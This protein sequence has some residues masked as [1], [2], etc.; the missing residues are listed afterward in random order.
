MKKVA[1]L[2]WTLA[3]AVTLL[4]ATPAPRPAPVGTIRASVPEFTLRLLGDRGPM[5]V[6]GKGGVARVAPGRYWVLGWKAGLKDEQGRLWTASVAQFGSAETSQL[7]TV[8]ANKPAGVQTAPPLKASLTADAVGNRVNFRLHFFGPGGEPCQEV[9]VDGALPPKPWLTIRDASG[10]QT[11]RM[12]FDYGCS[13]FCSTLWRA[14]QTLKGSYTVSV[15]FDFGPMR[16]EA[17]P[18]AS[19]TLEGVDPNLIAARPGAEAPDFTLKAVEDGEPLK[20]HAMRP[21]PTLVSFF[22]SCG[23]CAAVAKELAEAPAPKPELV[24][25]FNDPELCTPEAAREFR[26]QTGFR[27]AILADPGAKVGAEYDSVAC[28]RCWAVDAEGMVR[29]V[30][31]SQTTP[32]KEIVDAVRKRLFP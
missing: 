32:P 22:C 12:E 14:P 3:T 18:P 23:L 26:K 20:L 31:P 10:Q 24:A 6:H 7:I 1:L 19:F 21:R 29:Y 11:A 15:E 9:K 8:T 27:G 2:L 30:N 4:G 28:P 25:I 13:F 17:P 16:V 5:E